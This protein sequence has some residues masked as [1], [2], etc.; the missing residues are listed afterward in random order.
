MKIIHHP[1]ALEEKARQLELDRF[2]LE[3]STR[4]VEE[5]HYRINI[6]ASRIK[7]LVFLSFVLGFLVGVTGGILLIP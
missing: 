3:V 2:D 1:K 6:L 7:T 4:I 5:K